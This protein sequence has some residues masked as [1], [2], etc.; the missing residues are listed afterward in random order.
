[1]QVKEDFSP[2][3]FLEPINVPQAVDK[4]TGLSESPSTT[5]M[6]D[7]MP[8]AINGTRVAQISLADERNLLDTETW[9]NVIEHTHK[10]LMVIGIEQNPQ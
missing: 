1:M 10:L 3:V 9:Q 6:M 5:A 2:I 4:F 8:G 7:R